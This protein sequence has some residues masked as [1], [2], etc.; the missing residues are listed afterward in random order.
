MIKISRIKKPETVP[1]YDITVPETSSFVANDIVVHNCTE[2]TLP[3]SV[4]RTAVCCLSSLNADT[5][6]E[7]HG[8]SIV[9]DLIKM[10][11]NVLEYFIK[12]APEPLKKAAYSAMRER[13]TGLGLM[14]FHHYLQKH[15][16]AFE[17]EKARQIN[18]DMFTWIQNEAIAATKELAIAKGECP[19]FITQLT[20]EGLD[21]KDLTLF[22]SDYVYNEN[23]VKI[24][25]FEVEDGDSLLLEDNSLLKVVAIKGKHS[26]SGR[27]NSHLLA[28]APNANSA[29]LLGSSP[30]TEPNSANAYI[31]QTRA[32]SWPVKNKY[33][34][35]LM[36]KKG[37]NN[38]SMWQDIIVNKGSIQHIDIFTEEEKEVFKTA[39]EINQLWVVT[40]AA[41]RQP[42]ICQSQ[43]INLFFPP[44]AS[45]NYFHRVH[46][47]AWQMGMKSLYYTRTSTP[48]RAD[49]VSSKIARVALKD[50]EEIEIMEIPL[51]QDNQ[52]SGDA[53]DSDDGDCL[54]CQG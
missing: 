25:A 28:P 48:N 29:I 20:I 10:L 17:S 34:D 46:F 2:I 5:Y 13:A 19:D 41:D 30:G 37:I 50:G 8:T 11:D 18:K 16:V 38:D 1:V 36:T 27:R 26:H 31:H 6:D 42:M 44:R 35:K 14:G 52:I 54:A 15:M 47:M 21:G 39:I 12:N 4:D 43:S 7:W 33:L 9:R 3:T 53:V 24:R 40:H 51:V 49:N 23:G 22:S 32:G 45:R